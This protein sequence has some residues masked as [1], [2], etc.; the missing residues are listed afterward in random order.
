[1]LG[2]GSRQVDCNRFNFE[3]AAGVLKFLLTIWRF[4]PSLAPLDEKKT[5]LKL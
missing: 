2:K 3:T 4:D 5:L 1:M